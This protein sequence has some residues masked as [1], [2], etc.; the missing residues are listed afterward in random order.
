D[1]GTWQRPCDGVCPPPSSLLGRPAGSV[2]RG[3]FLKPGAGGRL[4]RAPSTNPAVTGARPLRPGPGRKGT[5]GALL[6]RGYCRQKRRTPARLIPA[7]FT[8][9]GGSAGSAARIERVAGLGEG[10]VGVGAQRGDGGDADHDDQGQHD[11]VLDRRRAVLTLQELDRELS[12]PAH[13]LCPFGNPAI[14]TRRDSA[15]RTRGFASPS[16]DGF[17]LI[18]VTGARP[19]PHGQGPPRV[20]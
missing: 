18:E 12:E 16:Y 20:L 15:P 8:A 14:R 10:G 19:G 4:G 5:N 3:R 9:A 1:A 7:G 6:G 13:L 11:R 2:G 17:G